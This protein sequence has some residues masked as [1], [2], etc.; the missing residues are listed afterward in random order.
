MATSRPTS[1]SA[2]SIAGGRLYLN[3]SL[4]IRT[5]WLA[6]RD[7]YIRDADARG[8]PVAGHCLGSQLVALALGIL[9]LVFG[10]VLAAATPL[11]ITGLALG[12]ALGITG[13]LCHCS[14][15]GIFMQALEGGRAA[16]NQLYLKIA[17]DRHLCRAAIL[18]QML[19]MNINKFQKLCL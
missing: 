4:D 7:R 10:S 17:A 3:Y 12:L 2:W 9:L 8:I 15:S 11:L 13:L 18:R 14:T 6:D 19:N 16:V 1:P 5:R